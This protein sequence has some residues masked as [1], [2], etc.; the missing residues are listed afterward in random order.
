MRGSNRTVDGWLAGWLYRT[1]SNT[2]KEDEGHNVRREGGRRDGR[3]MGEERRG[4]RD[5]E[6]EQLG[7]YS[8]A[9]TG[10]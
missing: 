6:W 5:R 8:R 4:G 10:T 7:G 3:I 9:G 2:S 1:I